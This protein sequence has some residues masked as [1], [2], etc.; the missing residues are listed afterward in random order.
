MLTLG[1]CGFLAAFLPQQEEQKKPRGIP[2]FRLDEQARL[3][4]ELIGTWL[5]LEYTNPH[6]SV[7]R[8]H[9]SGFASFQN[10][11]FSFLLRLEVLGTYFFGVRPQT[12]VNAGVHQFRVTENRLQTATVLAFTNENP[13]YEL[14]AEPGAFPR[15]FEITLADN[16]L[17]LRRHDGVEFVFRRIED[18]GAF[19]KQAADVLE[20][21][22]GRTFTAPED[23][24]RKR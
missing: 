20:R 11:Y 19:P 10:G 6:E 24:G 17:S 4:E 15:E 5:L 21:Y 23:F 7:E 12:I 8:R 14:E 16:Q 2:G 3:E 18:S 22:R 9:F 1:L 13:A